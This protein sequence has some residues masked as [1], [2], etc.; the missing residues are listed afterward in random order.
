MRI[1]SVFLWFVK[2]AV[3]TGRGISPDRVPANDNAARTTA[4][5]FDVALSHL[6]LRFTTAVGLLYY[7]LPPL[8]MRSLHD[9]TGKR[10][11]FYPDP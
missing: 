10:D 6:K 5:D 1:V 3:A 8:A 11:P 9:S 7:L 4:N 2:M